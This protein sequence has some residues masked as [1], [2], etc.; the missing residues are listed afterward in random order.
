MELMGKLIIRGH[1][2]PV[3]ENVCVGI[4]SEPHGWSDDGNIN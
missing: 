1:E 4:R 3:S 2:R